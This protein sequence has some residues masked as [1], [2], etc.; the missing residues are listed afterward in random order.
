MKD[1]LGASE[2][3]RERN[4]DNNK[5]CQVKKSKSKTHK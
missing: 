2:R 3:D 5:A 1:K 4:K